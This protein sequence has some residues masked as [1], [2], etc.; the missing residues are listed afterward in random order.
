MNARLF[1]LALPLVLAAFVASL[2]ARAAAQ[3]ILPTAETYASYP[4]RLAPADASS[5]PV[6]LPRQPAPAGRRRS[7]AW[8]VTG[9]GF[10]VVGF[11]TLLLGAL[12]TLACFAL[13]TPG[14]GQT[15]SGS[16]CWAAAAILP[17]PGA[18]LISA[19]IFASAYGF[20]RAPDRATPPL[21]PTVAIGPRSAS[22]VWRF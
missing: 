20:A 6:S 7:T 17:A 15:S 14:P 1:R 19:G 5:P 11:P 16:S 12:G 8:G 10:I 3:S 22:L 21:V 9:I 4:P 2:P 18:G 13:S